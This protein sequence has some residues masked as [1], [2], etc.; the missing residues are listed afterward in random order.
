M[1]LSEE[2]TP[3]P[4]EQELIDALTRKYEG[5]YDQTLLYYNWQH[6]HDE[7]LPESLRLEEMCTGS[8]S[9]SKTRL[10]DI[11]FSLIHDVDEHVPLQPGDGFAGKEQR[12]SQIASED[13]PDFGYEPSDIRI[14]RE[15]IEKTAPGTRCETTQERKARR[16]DISN[17]RN[18]RRALFLAKTVAIFNDVV[19]LSH[20]AGNETPAWREFVIKQHVTLTEL[21]K[22]DLTLGPE[23]SAPRHGSFNRMAM[24]NVHW[25]SKSVVLEPQ[26]FINRYERYLT[27]RPA[28]V[29][30]F[31]AIKPL[32][33]GE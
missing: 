14:I 25:L 10:Q 11:A 7:V 15:M 24:R 4:E 28:L 33:L 32:I 17:L 26:R 16:A 12:A 23:F 5:R 3:F 19:A 8:P 27:R 9:P 21:L 30:D 22:D 13:L 29:P 6:P 1:L 18:K 20:R 31:E 2:I